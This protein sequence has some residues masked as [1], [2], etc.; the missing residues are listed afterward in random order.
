ML[1]TLA[2]EAL[3]QKN[4]RSRVKK[5]SEHHIASFSLNGCSYLILASSLI[6]Q[7]ME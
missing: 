5:W 1:G 7:W 6:H 4:G 2:N 3:D